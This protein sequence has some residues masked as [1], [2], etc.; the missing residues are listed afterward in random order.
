LNAGLGAGGNL[1]NNTRQASDVFDF[2]RDALLKSAGYL[3]LAAAMSCLK[4]PKTYAEQLALLKSRGL[5][6]S[7]E[8]FA[9][10]VLAHHNYYRL[11]AYRFPLTEA[12]DAD[13]FLPGMTFETLWSLYA[14]DRQLRLMVSEA[15]KRVEISVR[16]HWAYVLGHAHGSQAFELSSVFS[17]PVRHTDALRKLDEELAR[18]D[19]PFV[20]HYRTRHGMARPPIWAACE[21]M[22]FGL[23]SRFY[24][25][26]ARDRDKKDIARPYRLFPETMKSLLEH[27]CHVRNLCAHHSRLWNRRFTITLTLPQSQPK[28]ILSSL[29]WEEDRRIYNTLVILGHMLDVIEPGHT[30]SSRLRTL[31]EAQLFPVAAHMGFPT[32]WQARAAWDVAA[33]V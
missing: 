33:G 8:G 16:S 11:S 6:V 24:A 25:N 28:E 4:S 15:L 5:V 31:I 26:V 27:T 30:W 2:G 12:G 17:N 22:S 19:E 7:D 3:F 21:V 23:L 18:S 20:S 14:F 9:L 1:L 10:H 13:R 29:N 32:D